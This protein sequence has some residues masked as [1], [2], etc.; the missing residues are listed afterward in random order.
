MRRLTLLLPLTLALACGD[1]DAEDS[2]GID[3]DGDGVSSVDD[4]DDDDANAFPGNAESCDGVDNNCDGVVDEDVKSV[5]F[6][7]ADGDLFG[8]PESSTEAC[9][10]DSGWVENEDDCDD[11]N[12]DVYAG[13][14]EDDCTDPVDY[15]CDG[16]VQYEDADGD[17]HAAC[18]DCDDHNSGI[19]ADADEVCDN[20]DNNCDGTIDEGSATDA[21][22]F[23][24]DLDE[25]GYG[26][27][28]TTAT[29]CYDAPEG[30]T[31]DSSDCDD[32]DAAVHPGAEEIC[33]GK[34]SDCD[35]TVGET[36]VPT[37]YSAIQDAIDAGEAEIC[38]E[39]GTYTENLVVEGV[40]GLSL[41]GFGSDQ[42]FLDG[43]GA[44]RV[45]YVS[46]STNVSLEGLTLQNGW[47]SDDF[48]GGLF[49][50]GDGAGVLTLRDLEFTANTA[51]SGFCLGTGLSTYGTSQ[52]TVEDVVLHDNICLDEGDGATTY[53]AAFF[54]YGTDLSLD[55]LEVYNEDTEDTTSGYNG[56]FASGLC[57]YAMTNVSANDLYVHD[58]S[59]TDTFVYA[60]A[61]FYGA[62]TVDITNSTFENNSSTGTFCGSTG[63]FPYAS[64]V[65][66]LANV[67]ILGNSCTSTGSVYGVFLNYAGEEATA[68][69]VIVAGNT[70]VGEDIEFVGG[71]IMAEYLEGESVWTNTTVYGNTSTVTDVIDAGWSTYGGTTLVNT[72]YSGNTVTAA[73][74]EGASGFGTGFTFEYS[75]LTDLG[76]TPFAETSPI[77]SDGNVEVASGFTDVSS[78]D[79]TAWDLTLAT[80]SALIDAGDP[81]ISDT[82]GTTSDIGAY[83]GPGAANW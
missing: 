43:G 36:L 3:A 69:N 66:S 10:A 79:P 55:G 59:A 51:A 11:T 37:D 20:L 8:D 42:V 53:G 34:D 82:D 73:G 39:A 32:D 77:G 63:L 41:T 44:D 80:G 50:E 62:E 75:N 61:T 49:F 48:A 64:Q 47:A 1:K 16:S 29:A 58:N 12:A 57:T 81:A 35:G 56:G 46:G 70:L 13:A 2:G 67:E 15:N 71:G 78:S 54:N 17:G 6:A 23:Y 30:F 19:N 33:D 38:V 60:A 18:E 74:Y 14:P 83:G 52:V 68:D 31:D 26:D 65:V 9:E 22:T 4:C 7:D 28:E 21:D 45:L 25:D 40:D 76:S 72:D 5:F 27:L 24:A